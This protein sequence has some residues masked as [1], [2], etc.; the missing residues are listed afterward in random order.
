MDGKSVALMIG[1]LAVVFL[2]L[3]ILI[4]FITI[5]GSIFKAIDKRKAAK[6][7]ATQDTPS[8]EFIAAVTAAINKVNPVDDGRNLRIKSIRKA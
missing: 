8:P 6:A 2:V 5:M 4:L 7:P 1:G 3:A